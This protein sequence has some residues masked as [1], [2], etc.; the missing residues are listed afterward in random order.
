MKIRTATTDDA[1]ALAAIYG[2]HVL[3]GFGTFEE[4]PPSTEEMARRAASVLVHGL[5]YLVAEVDGAVAGFAYASPFRTRAAYRYTVED[6][7]YIAS[8][9]L[10]QGLGKALLLAVIARAEALG[11][12]QMV[13]MIGDSCNLGSIAV[14][15]SCGFEPTGVFGGLGF[16]AGRW[17]DVV[18]MQRPLNVGSDTLGPGIDWGGA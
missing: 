7:V 16:K 13:A 15:R 8:D 3:H 1:A 12:R 10:G 2:H 11:L 17:V 6:S 9:R 14:H 18:T 5:P 4:V